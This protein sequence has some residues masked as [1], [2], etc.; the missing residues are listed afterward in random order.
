MREYAQIH[1]RIWDDDDFRNLSV[2]AQ[3]LYLL[4]L[5]HPT[6]SNAGVGDWRP[7]RLAVLAGDSKKADIVWA[8]RELQTSR[9]VYIDEETEEFLVRSFVRND[10]VL[11]SRNMGTAVAKSIK[12]I[13][14][15]SLKT[16]VIWELQRAKY[17]ENIRKGLESKEL[18]GYL[19]REIH[20]DEYKY[21]QLELNDRLNGDSIETSPIIQSPNQL[22]LYPSYNPQSYK[23]IPELY[24]EMTPYNK[25]LT[26]NNRQEGVT[27]VGNT[28][29]AHHGYTPDHNPSHWCDEDNPRCEQHAHIPSSQHVPPCRQCANVKAWFK[30]QKNQLKA[31]RRQQIDQCD[32]CDTNGLITAHRP[33]GTPYAYRCDHQTSPKT[34]P[35]APQELQNAQND[36]SHQTQ[37]P[38][39]QN[40]AQDKNQPAK[41]HT[42]AHT[43][44]QNSPKQQPT[45]KHTFENKTPHDNPKESP[46]FNPSRARTHLAVV[47]A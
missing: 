24:E 17:E 14:S 21:A 6:L 36:Q 7:A 30:Q 10:T 1:L 25:Q 32:Q 41:P 12:M 23:K 38:T 37:H 39:P 46:S 4:L 3:R 11:R 27:E 9:F 15:R 29:S 40:A 13:A 22:S 34:R 45:N 44:N 33:D 28:T 42:T 8:S 31:Q 47:S 35:E 43:T 20:P 26:T 2:Y 16:L 18:Q 5:S 19:N